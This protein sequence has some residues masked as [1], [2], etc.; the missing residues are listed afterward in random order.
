MKQT[1]HSLVL[2]ALFAALCAVC[3][4]I[5]IPLPMVPINLA[6]FAVHLSGAILGVRYG[7]LSMLIY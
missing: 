4:Q 1:T 6:L 7:F 2:A 3:S 5:A